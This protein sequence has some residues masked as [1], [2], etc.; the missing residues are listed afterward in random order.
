MCAVKTSVPVH[1]TRHSDFQ[2][3]TIYAQTGSPAN[4]SQFMSKLKKQIW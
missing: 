2:K 1:D 4:L 3:E